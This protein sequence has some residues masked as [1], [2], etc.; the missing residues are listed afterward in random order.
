[1]NELDYL[2][3][4]RHNIEIEYS[5]NFW[6]KDKKGNEIRDKEFDKI[7]DLKFIKSDRAGELNDRMYVLNCQI[8]K[9]Q[10]VYL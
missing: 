9:I 1:M 8:A 4:E 3:L 2:K 5:Q 6:K 10:K 7:V